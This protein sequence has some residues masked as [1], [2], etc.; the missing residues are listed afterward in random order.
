MQYSNKCIEGSAEKR[1]IG[2]HSKDL[3]KYQHTVKYSK[4]QNCQNQR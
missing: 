1:Q 4:Q 3:I 2:G